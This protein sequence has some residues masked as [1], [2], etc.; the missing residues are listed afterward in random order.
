MTDFD[1][2]L[3]RKESYGTLE[4]YLND[5]TSEFHLKSNTHF[6]CP[7]CAKVFNKTNLLSYYSHLRECNKTI[8]CSVSSIPWD[9]CAMSGDMFTLDMLTDSVEKIE[10]GSIEYEHYFDQYYIKNNTEVVDIKED[11][12]INYGVGVTLECS[13]DV[14]KEEPIDKF[15]EKVRR[16]EIPTEDGKDITCVCRTGGPIWC[17]RYVSDNRSYKSSEVYITTEELLPKLQ[18]NFDHI[19]I[20]CI[21]R[22]KYM[23]R[24]GYTKGFLVYPDYVRPFDLTQ[25][26][27]LEEYLDVLNAIWKVEKFNPFDEDMIHIQWYKEST[28]DDKG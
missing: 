22:S 7:N 27:T 1:Y 18:H 25:I 5:V 20:R 13:H 2:K 23:L 8:D 6:V 15:I 17:T 9:S 21:L 4:C 26:D 16:I 19:G 11:W 10:Y 12:D 3:S 14:G 24:S 28:V